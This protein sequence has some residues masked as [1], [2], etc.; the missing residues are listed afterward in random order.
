MT[1]PRVL[2]DGVEYVP[3]VTMKPVKASGAETALG[4]LISA[5]HL[6]SPSHG[7]DL[8]NTIWEAMRALQPGIDDLSEQELKNLWAVRWG[9]DRKQTATS[10]QED[11]SATVANNPEPSTE[12]PKSAEQTYS[13]AQVWLDIRMLRR[14]AAVGEAAIAAGYSPEPPTGELPSNAEAAWQRLQVAATE[15]AQIAMRPKAP[16]PPEAPPLPRRP[17]V[18]EDEPVEDNTAFWW[19]R[20]N[21]KIHWAMSNGNSWEPIPWAFPELREYDEPDF[22]AHFQ[23]ISNGVAWEYCFDIEQEVIAPT[24]ILFRHDPEINVGWIWGLFDPAKEVHQTPPQGTD[25]ED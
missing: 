5:T 4:A 13:G 15:Y 12:E 14:L 24:G 7:R 10:D 2:I 21:G 22:D 17:K 20:F 16:T 3:T 19:A 8:W 9:P 1:T 25:R 11:G 18:C 6:Y 23:K